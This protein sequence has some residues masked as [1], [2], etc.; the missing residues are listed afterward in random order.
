MKRSFHEVSK[1]NVV[2]NYM[3]RQ[4]RKVEPY[5]DEDCLK[6]L[7]NDIPKHEMYYALYE[8][9]HAEDSLHHLS[10]EDMD[11]DPELDENEWITEP[12]IWEWCDEDEDGKGE[13]TMYEIY[14]EGYAEGHAERH[15]ERHTDELNSSG[16]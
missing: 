7:T 3:P 6:L 1:D 9:V 5:V 10:S 12:C 11:Y 4:R 13:D 15:A 16:K 2:T 8:E 14:S